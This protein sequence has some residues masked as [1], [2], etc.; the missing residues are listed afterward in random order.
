MW[1]Y[2]Q[3]Q[4][5]GNFERPLLLAGP[6]HDSGRAYCQSDVRRLVPFAI[7]QTCW[8]GHRNIRCPQCRQ[9][10]PS[11]SPGQD[12]GFDTYKV[13]EQEFLALCSKQ[14]ALFLLLDIL[15]W[16]VLEW[17]RAG[18][19]SDGAI[20]VI[21]YLE[22]RIQYGSSDSWRSSN[23]CIS[24]LCRSRH[25]CCLPGGYGQTFDWTRDRIRFNPEA[26]AFHIKC[27]GP[28]A[29]AQ[30]DDHSGRRQVAGLSGVSGFTNHPLRWC[31]P[32]RIASIGGH[33][34]RREVDILTL[35]R[36]RGRLEA[37][38]TRLRN[39]FT[40]S[41]AGNESLFS[42]LQSS[43]PCKV[44]MVCIHRSGESGLTQGVLFPLH[45]EQT[46]HGTISRF[47]ILLANFWLSFDIGH[48]F[49]PW[50]SPCITQA[51]TNLKAGQS[52]GPEKVCLQPSIC[53]GVS[54]DAWRHSK[55]QATIGFIVWSLLFWILDPESIPSISSNHWIHCLAPFILDLGFEGF[56]L[57]TFVLFR[58][59]VWIL[60]I[61]H[62][63]FSSGWILE[64][65]YTS[66]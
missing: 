34:T 39:H 8:V 16:F 54:R 58:S 17:G 14:E 44:F 3:Q 12:L 45:Y 56:R 33:R 57:C 19:A 11:S 30:Q 18:V 31:S 62:D 63:R 5:A 41:D 50:Q 2:R 9:I 27:T 1:H 28:T 47:H 48:S 36:S 26:Q 49:G 22:R 46:I 13:Y 21:Y 35:G 29:G 42:E 25:H 40:L 7:G 20:F 51:V 52:W 24:R 53:S 43:T 64:G 10:Q 23:F 60:D 32:G 65:K 55:H 6:R 4:F 15:H 38:K 61:G 66:H 59:S 37:A